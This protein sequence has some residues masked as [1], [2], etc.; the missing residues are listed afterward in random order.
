[1][2]GT[3]SLVTRPC[4]LVSSSMTAN[5]AAIRSG[6]SITIVTAGTRR[7]SCSSRSPCGRV[8][9]VESPDAA[10]GGRAA[11]PGG[12]Q[13]ADDGAVDRLALVQRRL[14]GVDHELVP[15][16][17]AA[18]SVPGSADGRAEQLPSRLQMLTRSRVSSGSAQQPAQLGQYPADLLAR[19][20]RR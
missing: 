13:P 18:A 10:Q 9:A 7:P 12:A 1:M 4:C 6:V 2:A 20:R 17:H 14:G 5:A 3:T 15:Q 16:R 8:V 19:S 11:D